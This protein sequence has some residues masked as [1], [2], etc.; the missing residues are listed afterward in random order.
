[1]VLNSCKNDDTGRNMRKSLYFINNMPYF[2]FTKTQPQQGTSYYVRHSIMNRI[3][4]VMI[5]AM[6][7]HYCWNLR[8]KSSKSNHVQDKRAFK[9]NSSE[10]T[11][12]SKPNR[13]WIRKCQSQ[14]KIF[15]LGNLLPHYLPLLTIS[16]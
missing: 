8:Y 13:G 16:I 10:A 4:K 9:E 11:N 6:A 2:S 1:M 7:N 12:V 3:G 5:K 15:I 14:H